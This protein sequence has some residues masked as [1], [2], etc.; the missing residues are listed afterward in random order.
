MATLLNN[1]NGKNYAALCLLD[2]ALERQLLFRIIPNSQ[3]DNRVTK[4]A[5]TV[6]KFAALKIE[7]LDRLSV[8]AFTHKHFYLGDLGK[9]VVDK[10]E[11]Q[12]KLAAV[13]SNKSL[14]IEE[15]FYLATCNRVEFILNTPEGFSTTQAQELLETFYHSFSPTQISNLLQFA[16]IYRGKEAVRHIFEVSCSM[17]SMVIGEREISRQLRQ[18]YED[19]RELG[20]TG[21]F[22][23][24][25]MKQAVKTSKEVYTETRIAA[26]PISVASLAVR[27]LIDYNLSTNAG[28]VL[29]G[30]GETNTLV[31]KYLK[32]WGYT[33]YTIYNRTFEKAQSLA[34]YLG[35]QALP[36]SAL[37]SHDRK[38]SVLISCTSSN[39]PLI[40]SEVW[41]NLQVDPHFPAVII[42]LAVPND[43]AVEVRERSDVEYISIETLKHEVEK[44]LEFREAELSKAAALIEKSIVEFAELNR[45]RNVELALSGFP[46]QVKKIKQKALDEVFARELAQLDE[47]TRQLIEKMMGYMEK[48]CI[49]VPIVVAKQHLLESELP[50]LPAVINDLQGKPVKVA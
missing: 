31:A 49:S 17:D 6:K 50:E 32:K 15:L 12:S 20:A 9:L 34:N 27:K 18:A 42:D 19:G 46:E 25:L 29:I 37:A 28:I 24:L 13:L 21:D 14:C 1:A 33:N 36:L 40:T 41:N 30:A 47:H 2:R 11:L 16:R 10:V 5:A 22:L 26:K 3:Y 4:E 43:V 23:R 45:I 7:R 38:V 44:N 35:G 48:K 8:L 39:E